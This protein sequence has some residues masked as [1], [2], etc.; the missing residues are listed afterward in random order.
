[1]GSLRFSIWESASHRRGAARR[2]RSDSV[3]CHAYAN[4]VLVWFGPGRQHLH[5]SDQ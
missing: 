2:I 3:R 4:A 1:M 5:R